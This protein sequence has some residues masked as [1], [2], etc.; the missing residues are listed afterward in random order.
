MHFVINE[1]DSISD[2][3]ICQ[4]KINPKILYPILGVLLA[5][6]VLIGSVKPVS[7]LPGAQSE[8]VPVKG[9]LGYKQR[10]NNRKE[11]FYEK[12]TGGSLDVVSLLYGALRFDWNPG[13][14]L[15]VLRLFLL[16]S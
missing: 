10:S 9:E 14:V 6:V 5:F 13:V 3:S 2:E 8:L 16:S 4:K 12:S 11:G 7:A 1:N 15:E